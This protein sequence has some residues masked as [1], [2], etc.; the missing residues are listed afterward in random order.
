M[1]F[2]FSFNSETALYQFLETGILDRTN[3][4]GG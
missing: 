4:G 3:I 1:R 2:N